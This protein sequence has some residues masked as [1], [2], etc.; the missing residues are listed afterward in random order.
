MAVRVFRIEK[1]PLQPLKSE[2]YV[3][4]KQYVYDQHQ[5]CPQLPV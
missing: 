3:Q 4:T 2:I 1:S 5:V